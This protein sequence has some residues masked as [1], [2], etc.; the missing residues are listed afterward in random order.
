MEIKVNV[1]EVNLL[2]QGVL[3]I[4]SS[5][6]T[7]PVSTSSDDL[8][9]MSEVNDEKTSLDECLKGYM[10]ALVE[11]E[12]ELQLLIQGYE[13]TD[14]EIGREINMRTGDNVNMPGSNFA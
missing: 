10:A 12:T 9:M 5:F 13:E 4:A 7:V 3:E 6:Q 8:D 14:Q 1:E 11:I 2:L